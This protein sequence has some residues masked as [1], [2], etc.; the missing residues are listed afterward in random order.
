MQSLPELEQLCNVLYNGHDPSERAH[1]ENSLRPFSVN[2]DYIPQ[3]KV[4]APT[5]RPAK[6]GG[7]N[8]TRRMRVK[9]IAPSPNP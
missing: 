8:S 6:P 9:I 3:C 2:V 5:H 1:A 4:R 7:R